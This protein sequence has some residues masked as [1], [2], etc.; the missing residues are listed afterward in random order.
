MLTKTIAVTGGT[1][2]FGSAFI[3]FILDKTPHSVVCISRGDGRQEELARSLDSERLRC[4][5]VDVTNYLGMRTALRGVDWVVHAAAL[6]RVPQSILYTDEYARVNIDGTRMTLRASLDSGVE[7]FLFISTDKAVA[8]LNP[9]GATKAVAEHLTRQ[10]N[11]LGLKAAVV[12]GGNVWGSSGSVVRVWQKYIEDKLPIPVYGP[13]TTRFYLPMDYWVGFCY[14]VLE[15]MIGG[16]T[17]VPKLRA[18]CLSDLAQALDPP[19]GVA[20]GKPRAGDKEREYLISQDEARNTVR[21][22]WA[23]V[24]NPPD[25]LNCDGWVGDV[26]DDGVSSNEAELLSV[27]ELRGLI[28]ADR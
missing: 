21:L 18:W 22:D 26:V 1:G 11:L 12:R 10:Y 4:I 7:K 13:K 3:K 8:A 5:P 27:E 25:E 15:T 2:S 16:E 28:D 9:Y 14:C 6:K 17:F 24:V 20:I 19:Q 23:Y